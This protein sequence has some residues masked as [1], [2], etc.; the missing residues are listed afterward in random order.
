[1]AARFVLHRKR[2]DVVVAS[3]LHADILTDLGRRGQRQPGACAQRKLESGKGVPFDVRA[4][5]RFSARYLW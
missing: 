2:F 5:P 3:N 1:M 4:G